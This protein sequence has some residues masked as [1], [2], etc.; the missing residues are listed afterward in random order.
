MPTLYDRAE[1]DRL[2]RRD[3]PRDARGV[4]W[5]LAVWPDGT[6]A[7]HVTYHTARSALPERWAVAL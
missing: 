5:S 3:L 6:L 4:R 2:A 1:L 7:L